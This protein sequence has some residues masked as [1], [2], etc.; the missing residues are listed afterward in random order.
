M[1]KKCSLLKIVHD[2]FKKRRDFDPVEDLVQSFDIA[3]KDNKDLAPLVGKTQV[4]FL[5]VLTFSL[6]CF[7]FIDSDMFNKKIC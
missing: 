4:G 7:L 6:Y 3:L 1:V 2:K 5:F